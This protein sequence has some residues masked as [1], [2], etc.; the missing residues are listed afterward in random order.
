MNMYVCTWNFDSSVIFCWPSNWDIPC[1][2]K[3]LLQGTYIVEIFC[4]Y[5]CVDTRH[6]QV[7][8]HPN[9]LNPTS[10]VYTC[11]KDYKY[12]LLCTSNVSRFSCVVGSI[13]HVIVVTRAQVILPDMFTWNM[14][15]EDIHTRSAYV[16][17]I[18][19]HHPP[20]GQNNWIPQSKLVI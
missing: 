3:K 9:K 12:N 14:R 8:L 7:Y 20:I 10:K 11:I 2:N 5:K 1:D 19:Y 4:G 13:V 6:C 16:V 17:T 18:M 15:S